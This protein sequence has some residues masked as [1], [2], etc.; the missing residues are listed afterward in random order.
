MPTASAIVPYNPS[1]WVAKRD[2]YPTPAAFTTLADDTMTSSACGCFKFRISTTTS[3][4]TTTNLQTKTQYFGAKRTKTTT[5]TVTKT[6]PRT[7]STWVPSTTTMTSTLVDTLTTTPSTTIYAAM[8]T[9]TAFYL[10]FME[11]Q[12]AQITAD[13]VTLTDSPAAAS[14]F[15]FSGFTP[16]GTPRLVTEDGALAGDVNGD[17]VVFFAPASSNS[18]STFG[19]RETGC[20][21]DCEHSG[22]TVSYWWAE[23]GAWAMNGWEFWWANEDALEDE[24][25]GDPGLKVAQP[26]M[27]PY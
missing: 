12:Y 26:Y 15:R 25:G 22:Q 17:G 24:S 21:M 10:H 18:T 14:K 16:N 19:C 23:R 2:D 13:H 4:S 5:D 3:T 7:T 20:R 1:S 9:P 27:R 6:I 11:T 8:E